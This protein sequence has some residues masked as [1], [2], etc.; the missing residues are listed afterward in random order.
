VIQSL[1]TTISF[2]PLAPPSVHMALPLSLSATEL[3]RAVAT[4]GTPL[5]VYSEPDIK[6]N[7]EELIGTMRAAFPAFQQFYAVKA[8]PNPAVLQVLIKVR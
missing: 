5:Q 4:Y 7:A 6:A 8:L 2:H 3:E 1:N